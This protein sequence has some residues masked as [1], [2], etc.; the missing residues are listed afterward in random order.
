MAERNCCTGRCCEAFS[1]GQMSPEDVRERAAHGG[2][3]EDAFIAD[4][5]VPLG[6]FNRNPLF[7][8]G[9]ETWPVKEERP[10]GHMGAWFYTCRHFDKTTRSCTAYERRPT[11]CRKFPND[12]PCN[13][14]GCEFQVPRKMRESF[15]FTGLYL[16]ERV[17]LSS[18]DIKLLAQVLDCPENPVYK[19]G[20]LVVKDIE[21]GA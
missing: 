20:L 5:L 1:L 8:I 2:T 4:M 16:A 17:T 21:E 10:G 19:R 7:I 18:E 9:E 15:R 6:Y 11:M 13:Y 12:G 3:E 14:P